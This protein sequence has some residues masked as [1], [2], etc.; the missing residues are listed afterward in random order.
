MAAHVVARVG[1]IPSGGRKT[2]TVAGKSVVL[3]NLHGEYFAL[4][5]RC[6]H[7]GAPL[8][9]GTQVGLLE[10]SVP[11]EYRYSRV[12]EFLRCPW[13]GWEFDIRTG[14]SYCNP[15]TIRAR[16]LSTRVEQGAN[17]VKG[18]YTV[19]TFEVAVEERYIV[20]HI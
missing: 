1:E 5:N 16:R 6:P 9:C 3:F 15:N 20:L 4:L 11:G 17:I 14:Q 2:L 7:E 12:G 13:H 10:S 18:P 19:D 8:A